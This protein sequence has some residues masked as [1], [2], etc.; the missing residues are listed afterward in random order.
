MT[1][2]TLVLRSLRHRWRGHVGVLLGAAVGS[3]ALIGALVVGDSVRGSLR[4]QAVQRLGWVDDALAPVDRYFSENLGQALAG[5]DAR[6][7]AAGTPTNVVA[8]PPVDRVAVVL[9]LPATA[10]RQD[11]SARANQVQVLGVRSNFWPGSVAGEL[12]A[13]P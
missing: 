6:A 12:A 9:R 4:E 5:S 13:L 11:G 10:A 8:G 7:A 3:A 1:R 2:R